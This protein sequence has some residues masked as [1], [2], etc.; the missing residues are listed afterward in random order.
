MRLRIGVDDRFDGVPWRFEVVHRRV[1]GR[2]VV[3]GLWSLRLT[4]RFRRFPRRLACSAFELPTLPPS[5]DVDWRRLNRHQ[6]RPV[7]SQIR[8]LRFD[9]LPDFFRERLASDLD[10][11]RRPE[12]EENP[13]TR[14][15]RA[16][17]RGL[18]QVVRL[19]AALVARD[20]QVRHSC[21][22]LLAICYFLF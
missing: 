13:R 9:R 4:L 3:V 18:E 15:L 21:N 7:E 16:I 6:P 22:L 19:V 5:L 20:L 8:I 1:F 11:R 2:A 12:P 10:L 14:L 17:R